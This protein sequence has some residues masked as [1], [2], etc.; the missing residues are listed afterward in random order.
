M[1]QNCKFGMNCLNP[2]CSFQHNVQKVNIPCIH[3]SRG[4]CFK[5][6]H[7]PYLHTGAKGTPTPFQQYVKP[8]NKPESQTKT[9]ESAEEPN[10]ILENTEQKPETSEQSK[11]DAVNIHIPAEDIIMENTQQPEESTTSMIHNPKP[12][13]T[14]T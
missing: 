13:V 5:G 8:L 3:Y 2:K 10:V 11:E 12:E 4:A 1:N 9:Q 14:A 7:C 6:K